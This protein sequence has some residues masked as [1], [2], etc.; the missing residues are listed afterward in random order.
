MHLHQSA[1]SLLLM[2]ILLLTLKG[3]DVLTFDLAQFAHPLTV[4]RKGKEH[5]VDNKGIPVG[6]GIQLT[7]VLQPL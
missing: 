6:L 7:L 1:E 4:V 3:L 5:L 2:G